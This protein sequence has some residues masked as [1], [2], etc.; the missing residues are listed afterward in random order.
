MASPA[1]SQSCDDSSAELIVVEGAV[2]LDRGAL[3][4]WAPA[5]VGDPVCV[6]DLVRVQAFSRAALRLPDDTVLRLDQNTTV[7]WVAPEGQER[8]LLDVLR[9]IIHVISRDPRALSFTTPFVNAGLEG[10]EFVIDVSETQTAITVLEGVVVMANAAGTAEINAGERGTAA[11][12][13]ATAVASVPDTTEAVRWALYYAPVLAEQ[14]PRPDRAPLAQ[15]ERDPDF[16]AGRAAA[17]LLVGRVAEAREDLE[18]ALTLDPAHADAQALQ[19]AIAATLN[20]AEQAQR[21]AQAAVTAN[22]DS[23]AASIALAYA[24]QER[25]D[26]TAARETLETAVQQ[27]PE[28]AFAWARLAE[29]R[30]ATGSLAGGREAAERATRLQ[31][32]LAHA[33]T[34]LGFA[35]LMNLALADAQ[36]SFETAVDLDAAAPLAHLGL[37]LALIRDGNLTAG[38]REIEL[39]VLLD[40]N[41]A[42]ARSY[43]AKAYHE[44]RRGG[45]PDSQLTL[46]KALDPAEP[47]PWLYDALRKQSQNQPVEALQDL[48]QAAALNDRQTVYR[49]RLRID[50]DLAVRSGAIGRAYRDLGFGRLALISGWRSVQR[51][52]SDFSGRR[53]LADTYSM[54]PRHQIARVNALFQSQ[55]LQP[56]NVTAIPPQLAETN[57]FILD[58]AGPA[59]LAFNEF[60]PLLTRNHWSV[61]GAAIVAGNDTRGEHATISGIQDE[62]S[63]SLGYFG[64]ETDGFRENNDLDTEVRNAFVQYRPTAQTSLLAEL[65]ST[66]T[67]KGDLRLLFDPENYS[68]LLRQGDSTD[69]L[70]LGVRHVVSERSEILAATQFQKSDA[71]FNFGEAFSVSGM[72]ETAT[73]DAQHLFRSGN[74]Q[75][76]SGISSIDFDVD[77]VTRATIPLPFPPFVVEQVDTS[78]MKNSFRSAYTYAHYAVSDNLTATV[79]ASYDALDGQSAEREALNPKLGLIWQPRPGTTVRAAAFRTLQGPIVSKHNLL[80]R[81]EPVEVAGFNQFFFGDEGDEV[82]RIGVGIDQT[83][84]ADVFV[85]AEL[86]RRSIDR[87]IVVVQPGPSPIPSVTQVT[88]DESVASAYAYWTPTS[89]LALGAELQI[90]DFDNNGEVLADG[91]ANLRTTR[92]PL[93]VKYFHPSGFSA[94]LTTTYVDQSGDF[95]TLFSGPGGLQNVVRGDSDQFWV[96]DTNMSYR[97]PNRRGL[98]GLYVQN[99]LDE[100]FRFQDTDPENPRIMSSRLVSLR[101]TLAF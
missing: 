35:R 91:F 15:E 93:Q 74:W 11:R 63:Y 39:A 13:V 37:G 66:D 79:G 55:L 97:L 99:L 86:A 68:P 43:V 5:G 21:L 20:D 1:F 88:I 33:H 3:G 96:A 52:P 75:L 76:V 30:L 71:G 12:G 8:S 78:A 16:F 101:V 7:R 61:Q 77:E 22:P 50:E 85:G 10:T 23:A 27:H 36:Q 14:L 9:G 29:A 90:A 73:I 95:G 89:S 6:G 80:P 44:E 40:P 18:R 64:Y 59:D 92:L 53:L 51:D 67:V 100:R 72:F 24:R 2:D 26:L 19:A 81:L 83:L 54:L 82:T 31:P 98:I 56:L 48:E 17:R 28:N 25:F 46:A 70:R 41:N 57:M 47:T 45:L 49:S 65:R 38:R 62:V 87:S 34:V 58:S 32:G 42:L 69:S 84:A 94:G 4:R 60:N